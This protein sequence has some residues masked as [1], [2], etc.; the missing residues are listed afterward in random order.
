MYI[1]K[2]PRPAPWSPLAW[3]CLATIP[4]AAVGC[5]S[6]PSRYPPTVPVTGVV[7]HNGEPLADA[8]LMFQGVDKEHGAVARTDATGNFRLTTYV[9]GDG[10]EV[11][12]YEVAVVKYEAAPTDLPDGVSPPLKSLLPVRYSKAK[13]SGLTAT[14]GPEGNALTFDL[15]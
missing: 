7:T 9:A 10:A 15:Q 13:T 2:S 11:G 6:E 5:F 8:M 4:W 12:S 3:V 1:E 14:I